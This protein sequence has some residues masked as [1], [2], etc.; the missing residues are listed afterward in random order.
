M[1]TNCSEGTLFP[2]FCLVGCA[3]QRSIPNRVPFCGFRVTGQLGSGMLLEVFR[4]L[5][6]RV[7]HSL[8]MLEPCVSPRKVSY[9]ISKYEFQDL[10]N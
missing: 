10:T 6:V 1:V 4:F 3:L 9:T 5:G 8:G 2:F 7:V